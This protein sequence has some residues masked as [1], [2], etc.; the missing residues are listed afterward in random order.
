MSDENQQHLAQAVAER[1]KRVCHLED[2]DVLRN[3]KTEYAAARS[4]PVCST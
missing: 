4:G 1:Q 3:L 2:I